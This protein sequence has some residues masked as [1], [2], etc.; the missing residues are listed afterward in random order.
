MT[1]TTAGTD[2]HLTDTEML[3]CLDHD[4]TAQ[5][6]E[7]WQRHLASCA[8]C[9][10][11]VDALRDQSRAVSDWLETAAF[12]ADLPDDAAPPTSATQSGTG[13]RTGPLRAREP[14]A[15]P[16]FRP[17]ASPWLRAAAILVLLAAPLAAF[18]SVRSW[19]TERVTGPAPSSEDVTAVASTEEPTVLRF[20][21]DPGGF[22]VRFPAGSEGV[23][24]LERS[25]EG[26][27]VLRSDGGEPEATVS[28]ALLRI[29]NPEPARYVLRLPAT[30]TGV[31]V[32]IGERTV[33]VSG[34]EI[35]RGAV[36]EL[37]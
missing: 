16:R 3:R 34:S 31:R 8:M 26:E 29:R 35:E 1:S 33:E 17:A 4:A 6:S 24:T 20:V 23:L 18:P 37:R 21:P 30:T 27:A 25:G 15:V 28:A 11:G 32:Q 36:V 7:R 12:E 22:V 9:A 10:E 2:R 14:R 19:V 5:E 13:D